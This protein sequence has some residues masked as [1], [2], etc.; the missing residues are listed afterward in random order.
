MIIKNIILQ[1]NIKTN[2]YVFRFFSNKFLEQ[3]KFKRE[4]KKF[5]SK[6]CRKIIE[7]NNF[8]GETFGYEKFNI[9]GQNSKI[10]FDIFFFYVLILFETEIN[11]LACMPY[12]FLTNF[13]KVN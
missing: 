11:G 4:N 1:N 12:H 9:I 13:G 6:F 7:R 8:I 3:I 2:F 5:L 10:K